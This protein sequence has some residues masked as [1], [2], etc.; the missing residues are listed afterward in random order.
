ML[1]LLSCRGV[2]AALVGLLPPKLLLGLRLRLG[3]ALLLVAG[4]AGARK[5]QLLL[6]RSR[7]RPRRATGCLVDTTAHSIKHNRTAAMCQ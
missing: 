1:L 4:G 2:A 7:L 6:C 3:L 5:L